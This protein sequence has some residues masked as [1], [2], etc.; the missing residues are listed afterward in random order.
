MIGWPETDLPALH[1]LVA[2]LRRDHAAVTAGLTLPYS[3]GAVEGQV[4]RIKALKSAMYGRA[5][6]DLLRPR[7]PHPALSPTFDQRIRPTCRRRSG[8]TLESLSV[9]P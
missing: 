6:L 7:V 2:S 9:D 3:S 8:R 4:N 1:T 5:N